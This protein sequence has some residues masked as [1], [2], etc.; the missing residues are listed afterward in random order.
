[1][2]GAFLYVESY[3]HFRESLFLV[4]FYLVIDLLVVLAV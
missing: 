1:M 2:E 3:I 4:F